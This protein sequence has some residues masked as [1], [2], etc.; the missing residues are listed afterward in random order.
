MNQIQQADTFRNTVVLSPVG[1]TIDTD[2]NILITIYSNSSKSMQQRYLTGNMTGRKTQFTISNAQP[3]TYHQGIYYIGINRTNKISSNYLYR[4]SS[5]FSNMNDMS[6]TTGNPQRAIWLY[7]DTIMCVIIQNGLNSTLTFLNWYPSLN[8]T[9]NRT[10]SVPFNKPYGLA[11]SNDDTI[12]YV[13]ESSATIYQLSTKTFNWS[14]LVLNENSTEVPM[15]LFIDSC[16]S[17]LWVLMLGF[18][19]RIYDRIYGN[20]LASWNMSILYP[21]L[22]DMVLTSTYELY[23]IDYS[24]NQLIH[25]G[26]SLKDQCAINT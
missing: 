8:F 13:S 22:Y 2:L 3:I 4:Y 21:T 19:I 1:L 20:E 18:D 23:L 12:I 7:N 24:M 11:K 26:S 6:L 14:I 9:R 10:I 25:Y 15:T 5:N 16:G 17:R